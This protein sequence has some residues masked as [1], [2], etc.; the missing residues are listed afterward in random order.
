MDKTLKENSGA[1]VDQSHRVSVR[2]NIDGISLLVSD[3]TFLIHLLVLKKQLIE[4]YASRDISDFGT[5]LF[6]HLNTVKHNGLATFE[7]QVA[8]KG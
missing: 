3:D 4:E 2:H 1:T 6:S 5:Q 8:E 7:N